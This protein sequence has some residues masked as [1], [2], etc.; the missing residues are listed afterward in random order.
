MYRVL[1]LSGGPTHSAIHYTTFLFFT[2][3]L[4]LRNNR[5]KETLTKKSPLRFDGWWGC[6]VW[7]ARD[8]LSARRVF[9]SPFAYLFRNVSKTDFHC[10]LVNVSFDRKRNESES[11]DRRL[12]STAPWRLS[13]HFEWSG[14][15]YEFITRRATRAWIVS[16]TKSILNVSLMRW[17][18]VNASSR[19]WLSPKRKLNL[20]IIFI[21]QQSAACTAYVEILS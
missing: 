4:P 9:G 3:F 16:K 13:F 19:R 5:R 21:A 10:S 14:G 7:D 15:L 1:P 12:L 20:H 2:P 6:G 8:N 17:M 11:R 18:D